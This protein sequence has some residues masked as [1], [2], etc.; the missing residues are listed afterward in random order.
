MSNFGIAFIQLAGAKSDNL[1][2]YVQEVKSI[3]KSYPW[4]EMIVVGELAICGASLDNA[5]PAFGETESTLQALAKD[6]GLWLVPGSIHELRDNK[7]YNTT[8]VINPDGDIIARYDKIFPFLPYEKDIEPGDEFVVFDV[9]GVGR[10]GLAIC[11][12][13]WFPEAMRTLSA[14]GAEVIIAP[15]MTNTIDRD[16]EISIARANSAVNQCYFLA[17]NVAGEQGNGRSV[18]YAPGGELIHEC[19]AGREISLID[20]DFSRV[21]RNREAG[22]NGLGQ[23]MKSFRDSVIEFPLHANI[24]AR[25]KSMETLGP[26][27]VPTKPQSTHLNA[28][29]TDRSNVTPYSPNK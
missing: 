24:S 9:P 11:Y 18:Y 16:V 29:E 6:T 15:T 7:I 4:I 1:D 22:W 10:I 3:A 12:D 8:P 27:Q 13:I 19:G 25:K 17:V 28:D 21:R 2:L 14:M 23:V 5:E 26:L 20:L